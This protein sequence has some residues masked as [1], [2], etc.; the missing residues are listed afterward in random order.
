MVVAFDRPAARN[1]LNGRTRIALVDLLARL[2]A[3]PDVRVV[4]LTGTDPAFSSGVDVKELL[5]EG[6]YDPPPTD[7]ARCL[8]AMR[9]PVIAAVNGACVS[10]GWRSRWRA[11]SSSRRI[12]RPSPI[13][14][15]YSG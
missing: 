4:V 11:G 3:D 15:P 9:T 5:A 6:A 12:G 7:P 1:A 2:D 10:G 8:R 14:T 13:R